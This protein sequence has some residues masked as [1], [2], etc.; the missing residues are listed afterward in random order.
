MRRLQR[1]DIRPGSRYK[2]HGR[3]Q[4]SISR[5]NLMRNILHYSPQAIQDLDEIYDYIY[6][7]LQNPIAAKNTIQGIRQ[8]ISELKTLDNIGVKVILPNGWETPYRFIQYKN[9][10]SF[11]R[12]INNDI[13]VDR[14]IYGK[15]DYIRILFG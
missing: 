15:S 14:V 4:I 5:K 12:Q 3:E 13:F 2:F 11:Y 6:T 8:S 9:Y 1:K 10:L 7:T